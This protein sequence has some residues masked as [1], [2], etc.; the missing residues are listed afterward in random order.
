MKLRTIN[1]LGHAIQQAALVESARGNDAAFAYLI[2]LVIDLG[3]IELRFRKLRLKYLDYLD[4]RN[5][6]RRK[7]V[8][9]GPDPTQQN[10]M[11]E[12]KQ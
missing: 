8:H 9:R 5:G 2:Q 10:K 6:T 1:T 11:S 12:V 4:W 3:H 7:L